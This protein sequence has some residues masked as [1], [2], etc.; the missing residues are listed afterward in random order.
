MTVEITL[1]AHFRKTLFILF[2]LRIFGR[3]KKY[4]THTRVN[5]TRLYF[6]RNLSLLCKSAR[7]RKIKNCVLQKKIYF[8][9]SCYVFMKSQL[10][11]FQL[12]R[13]PVVLHSVYIYRLLSS[14]NVL[15]AV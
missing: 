7:V 10:V 9:I 4:E 8:A 1:V 12:S 2:S 5:I 15:S 14:L 13:T 11:L 6:F 3:V